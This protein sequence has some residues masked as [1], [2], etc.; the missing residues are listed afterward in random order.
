MTLLKLQRKFAPPSTASWS[1]K[2]SRTIYLFRIYTITIVSSKFIRLTALHE[3]FVKACRL[4]SWA[5]PY[6]APLDSKRQ[7]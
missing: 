4:L 7:S 5:A 2:F 3:R 6:A 1:R